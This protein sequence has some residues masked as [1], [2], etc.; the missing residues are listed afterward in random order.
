VRRSKSEILTPDLL[1]R[2]IRAL[3]ENP[4]LTDAAD[5]CGVHPRTLREW[6]QKGLLPNPE[7][8]YAAL[9]RFARS[10]R[11]NVRSEMFGIIRKAAVGDAAH[12]GDPKWAQYLLERMTEPEEMTWTETMNL[13]PSAVRRHL[14][15]NPSPELL[16]DAHAAGVKIVALTP[17]EKQLP[18]PVIDGELVDPEEV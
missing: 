7:P 15:A 13:P 8:H 18:P 10:A 4:S 2:L 3:R 9:A 1:R 16:A 5:K 17:E 14:L 6:I 11:S 12:P